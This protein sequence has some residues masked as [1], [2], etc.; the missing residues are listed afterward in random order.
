MSE[1]K[2]TLKETEE[3]AENQITKKETSIEE[4]E[5]QA[6]EAIPYDA[7]QWYTIKATN[8]NGDSIPYYYISIYANGTNVTFRSPLD[9]SSIPNPCWVCLDA[10]GEYQI[11]LRSAHTSSETFVLYAAIGSVLGQKTITQEA[12]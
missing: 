2:E 1:T 5:Q 10:Y 9:N 4:T 11:E 3:I 8:E 6:G 12:P 7:R